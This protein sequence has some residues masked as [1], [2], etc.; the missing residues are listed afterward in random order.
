VTGPAGYAAG[1][2]VRCARGHALG[3]V[4]RDMHTG[5]LFAPGLPL[6][7]GQPREVWCGRCGRSYLVDPR[8]LRRAIAEKRRNLVVRD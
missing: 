6:G 1:P 4:Y 8:K 3:G 2:V 5:D 7:G